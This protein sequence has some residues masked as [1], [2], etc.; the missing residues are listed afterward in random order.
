MSF[1][2]EIINLMINKAEEKL[3]SA[4]TNYENFQYDDS[5]SR[6]YYAIYHAICAA[7]HTRGLEFSSHSQTLGAFNKEFLKT[8]QFNQ[9]YSKWIQSLVNM[10]ESGDYDIRSDITQQKANDAIIMSSEIVYSI[11]KYL[12]SIM[13]GSEIQ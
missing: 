3:N 12:D 8:N 11:K 9:K 4:K 7:L 2:K 10:R 13:D 6:S 5:A 1:D